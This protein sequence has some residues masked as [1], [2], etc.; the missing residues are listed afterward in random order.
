MR[1]KIIVVN[2]GI[3]LTI[4]VITYVVLAMSI[5]DVVSNQADRKREVVQALRAANA[6]LALDAL[7]LERWLDERVASS[8]VRAVFSAGTVQARQEAATAQANKL[9]DSAVSEPS[10][11]KM[12][13]ALVLFV[14]TQGVA[15]GRN[16][17]ALMRGDQVGG[18]YAGLA[19]VLKSGNTA[20]DI[21]LNRQ[22]QE[23]LLASYAPV[24]GD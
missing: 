10:F 14:D 22:R 21:W 4:A 8:D 1:W 18:A 7:R 12:A 20:S 11:E 13:P 3:V 9:R 6:Q 16:G 2:S 19:K 23:Q 17:S 24:R 15:L 5:K